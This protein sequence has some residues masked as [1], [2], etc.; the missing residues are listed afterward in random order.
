MKCFFFPQCYDSI[1]EK[2]VQSQVLA[3]LVESAK[4]GGVFAFLLHT[5]I[6]FC[7]FSLAFL[8]GVVFLAYERMKQR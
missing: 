7:L 6:F 3:P 5:Y 2:G 8:A 1:R 4:K